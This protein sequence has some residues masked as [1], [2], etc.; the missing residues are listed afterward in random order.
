MVKNV[1]QTF[2]NQFV[3]PVVKQM[4]QMY[5]TADAIEIRCLSSSRLNF[6][7]FMKVDDSMIPGGENYPL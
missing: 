4:V 1:Q 6:K 7:T 2:F 5:V 3:K